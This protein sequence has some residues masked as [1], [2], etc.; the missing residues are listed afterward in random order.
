MYIIQIYSLPQKG[1]EKVLEAAQ[2][3]SVDSG[4]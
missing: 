4:R 2:I 3:P 1:D